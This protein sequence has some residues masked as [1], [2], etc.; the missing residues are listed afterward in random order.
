MKEATGYF[1]LVMVGTRRG[2][3]PGRRKGSGTVCL[4]SSGVRQAAV[5]TWHQ[6]CRG[7]RGPGGPGGATS[8][9]APCRI[10][11]QVPEPSPGADPITG[12]VPWRWTALSSSRW[13]W[14][15]SV[16]RRLGS[17]PRLASRTHS[18]MCS[19]SRLSLPLSVRGRTR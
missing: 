8:G 14:G 12:A 5:G 9:S 2:G 13:G 11:G 4:T 18:L 7:Q 6:G 15:G 16:G 3:R 1:L 10:P 19:R 17:S